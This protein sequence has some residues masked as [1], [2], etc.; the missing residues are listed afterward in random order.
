MKNIYFEFCSVIYHFYVRKND[1]TP[2]M[3]AFGA[4]SLM[5]FAN[6][7]V[8]YDIVGFYIFPQL[9]FSITLVYLL[10][11]VI[12]GV[13][14]ILVFKPA[15]YKKRTPKK[16]SGLYSVLYIVVSVLLIIWISTK[17]RDR[18]LQEKQQ[19]VMSQMWR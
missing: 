15:N 11:G 6:L 14:Y 8:V 10:F 1:N 12:C 19:Q 16:N 2:A 3:Y 5:I 9:P 4:S 18:Y 7:Y 17:H 13:N